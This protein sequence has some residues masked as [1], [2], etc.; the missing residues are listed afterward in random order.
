MFAAHRGSSRSVTA[1]KHFVGGS[2]RFWC[3]WQ[4]EK[5]RAICKNAGRME[6]HKPLCLSVKDLVLFRFIRVMFVGNSY[7]IGYYYW[8]ATIMRSISLDYA[9]NNAVNFSGLCGN[10]AI[11]FWI[12]R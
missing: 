12:M 11:F 3:V 2:F 9:H 4:L 10:Y 8:D 5:I 6:Y 7:F 1:D